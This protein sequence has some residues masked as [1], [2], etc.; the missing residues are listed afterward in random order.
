MLIKFLQS[1][2]QFFAFFT[3]FFEFESFKTLLLPKSSGIGRN[4]LGNGFFEEFSKLM[5][6]HVCVNYLKDRLLDCF[7]IESRFLGKFFTKPPDMF[8]WLLP[9]SRVLLA[10][11]I[12]ST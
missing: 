10:K 5:L 4:L 7:K 3:I 12:G 8:K 11:R 9:C 2:T 1:V 6:K